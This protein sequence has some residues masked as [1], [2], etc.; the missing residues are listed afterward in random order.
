MKTT[1]QPKKLMLLLFFNLILFMTHGQSNTVTGKVIS[2]DD[3]TP[4]PGVTIT[5]EGTTRGTITDIEGNFSIAAEPTDMLVVSFLGFQTQKFKVG[6]QTT[7][8]LTLAPDV[9]A[10]EEV[11]V[12]GYGAVKKS[13]LTGSVS[14]IKTEEITAFPVLSATQALQGRAAGVQIQSTNGGQPGASYSINIRGTS[15][16]SANNSPLRVVDGFVNAEMPPAEDIASIEILKDASATAIYGSRGANGVIMITTKKGQKGAM[17]VDFNSSYSFQKPTNQLDLLDGEEFADYMNDFGTYEYQGSNT[18]WQDVIMRTGFVYNSQLSVSGGTDK[19]KYYVSGTY[20]DQDGVV[21]GSDYKRYSVNGTFD[22]N[23]SDR[24]TLGTNFYG[25]RS[26]TAGVKTQEGTGGSGQAGVIGSAL[27]FNPDLG[28]YDQSGELMTSFLGGAELDNPY[29]LATEYEREAVSDRFQTNNFVEVKILDWLKFKSTL[30]I[31]TSNTREGNFWPTTLIYGRGSDG[32]ASIDIGK[33]VNTLTENY[34]TVDKSFNIHKFSWTTGFSQQ[35]AESESFGAG[36]TGFISNSS[37]YWALDQG[38]EATTPD[39]RIVKS[40]TKSFYTRFNYSLLDRYKLTTTMRYDGAS[41]FSENK[42]WA[43]FPSMAL[44]WNVI[45]EPFM[46]NVP[47]IDDFKIRTSFGRSGNQ[48]I[49]AYGTLAAYRSYY[50]ETPGENSIILDRLANDDLTWETTE[51]FDLGVDLAF[52]DGR[53]GFILDL[54]QK[55]TYDLLYDRPLLSYTGTYSGEQTQNSGQINNKGVEV[56]LNSKNVV[57]GDFSWFTDF[58]FSKNKNKLVKLSDTLQYQDVGVYP[59]HLLLSADIQRWQ[60][61]KPAGVFYG[62]EYL[63]IYQY[64]DPSFLSGG[65]QVAG[66]EKFADLN[67]DGVLNNKDKK[68]IGN[69][70]PKFS[71]SMNN[72]FT[73]KNFDLNVY[74]I[75]VHGQDMLDFTLME[76]ETFA[77]TS[78]V[79]KKALQRWTPENPNTNVPAALA[80]RSYKMSDRFIYDASYIRVKNIVLGYNVPSKLLKKANIRR[81]RVYASGQNMFIFTDYPGLD[82]ETAYRSSSNPNA[83]VGM[84]Y[85]GYPNVKAYTFG[86][87]VGF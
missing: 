7:F 13:D 9:Q 58:I 68:I 51:Q 65:D 50:S 66:G 14:S 76:L 35:V 56:T 34:F 55:N 18:D 1:L 2:G 80:G 20:F 73:Y 31:S 61:G 62:Y 69:P 82:P 33:S 83:N 64:S 60:I 29:A 5:L 46:D 59:G 57:A 19:A 15:S 25:R 67:G 21:I 42:K 75:G 84:S 85:A 86:V 38:S 77:G 40:V 70:N 71:W 45:D 52:L 37:S 23:V 44:A 3:N 4:L 54:Y 26:T 63:G 6:E 10:L 32:V 74:V 36:S 22:F 72:T 8:N 41:N 87:N 27:R 48:A 30:G 11:V 12:V 28:I 81:L 24:I 79:T 43:F 78:N 47:V 16:I 39:S 49:S 53:L 17:K